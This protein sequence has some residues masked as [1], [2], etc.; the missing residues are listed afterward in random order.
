MLLHGP[1]SLISFPSPLLSL[2]PLWALIGPGMP[3]GLK[4]LEPR[5][6]SVSSQEMTNVSA[7]P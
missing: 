2:K 3:G 4:R 6:S 7:S 5:R 1:M